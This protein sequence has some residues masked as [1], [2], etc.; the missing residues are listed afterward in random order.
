MTGKDEVVAPSRVL[1][2]ALDQLGFADPRF[3]FDDNHR[4]VPGG[5]S[6]DS[7]DGLGQLRLSS[8]NAV[9]RRH[10]ARLAEPSA[11]SQSRFSRKSTRTLV[12]DVDGCA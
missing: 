8:D 7:R 4:R 9:C 11:K 2:E 6:A 5:E 12:A 10:V 1:H 3:A